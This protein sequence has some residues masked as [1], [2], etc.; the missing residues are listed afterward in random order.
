MT[1]PASWAELVAIWKEKKPLQ[2]RQLEECVC[3]FYHPKEIRLQADEH[4]FAASNLLRKASRD[5][6]LNQFKELFGFEGSLIVTS[7][8]VAAFY[9][10]GK[11]YGREQVGQMLEL[12]NNELRLQ[13]LNEY[14]LNK[15]V[16]L[17]NLIKDSYHG[18]IYLEKHSTTGIDTFIKD[19]K[20]LAGYTQKLLSG[21]V[22]RKK[23]P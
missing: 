5:L 4:S 15:V 13:P 7:A 12:L 1:L 3:T 10:D 22:V 16:A 14:E 19:A 20:E 17:A 6:L 18:P 11:F 21:Q 9:V 8:H 23:S 2:A